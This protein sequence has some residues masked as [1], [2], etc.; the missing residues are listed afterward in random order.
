MGIPNI[1]S[2]AAI[3]LGIYILL[4]YLLGQK[5][6]PTSVSSSSS[7]SYTSSQ[8]ARTEFHVGCY[9]TDREANHYSGIISKLR[10]LEDGAWRKETE[11]RTLVPG[12][13]VDRKGV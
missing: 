9:L 10:E 4:A 8:I 13:Y 5:T 11:Y 2:A 6:T 7:A 3:I 12:D 1:L